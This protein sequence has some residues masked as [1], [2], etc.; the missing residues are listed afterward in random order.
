[1]I[2]LSP[3]DAISEPARPEPEQCNAALIVSRTCEKTSQTL[4]QQP[5]ACEQHQRHSNLRN[6][7]RSA[8]PGLAIAACNSGVFECGRQIE[9]SRLERGRQAKHQPG[10]D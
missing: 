1:M 6:N 5:G 9:A 2:G 7:E 4:N 10:D 3:L 8:K